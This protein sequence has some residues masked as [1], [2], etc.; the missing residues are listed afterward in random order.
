[1]AEKDNA[2]FA[3]EETGYSFGDI[4]GAIDT[5]RSEDVQ[6]LN[7]YIISNNMSKDKE[8]LIDYYQYKIEDAERALE[9]QEYALN[10]LIDNYVKTS[11]VF[12][13]IAGA[14][15]EQ[16]SASASLYEF[17]QPS[18]M[19]DNLINQKVECQTNIS[20]TQEQISLYQRR[21]ERLRNNES[22]GSAD[23]LEARLNAVYGKIERLLENIRI[24]SEEFF[25]TVELNRAFQTIEEPHAQVLP[26]VAAVRNSIY[27]ILTVEAALFS[28]YILSAF[29]A[30]YFPGKRKASGVRN[31]AREKASAS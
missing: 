8:N 20:A 22:S 29:Y 16:E 23:I 17:S 1:M 13:N 19:Y 7:S 18:E 6:W 10:G 11:A 30:V 4:I 9:Q 3:S 5:L 28:V 14:G 15:N 25:K 27:D 24:T 21:I 26:I 12:P 2:R 31:A